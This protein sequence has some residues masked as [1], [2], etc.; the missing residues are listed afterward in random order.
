MI[1]RV[2]MI[3][4]MRVIMM[5]QMRV[6]MMI[7]TSMIVTM[8]MIMR[9]I[10]TMMIMIMMLGGTWCWVSSSGRETVSDAW[11]T[12]P[13]NCSSRSSPTSTCPPPTCSAD[14]SWSRPR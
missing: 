7:I 1:M 14:S 4:V 5:M 6:I 12:P 10:V 9:V 2:K 8:M 3:M 13:A 11:R